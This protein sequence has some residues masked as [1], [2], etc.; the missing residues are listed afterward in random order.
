MSFYIVVK[1]ILLGFALVS[2]LIYQSRRSD[3]HDALQ[4]LRKAPV[5]RPLTEQ[6]V[7]ALEPLKVAEKLLFRPEVRSL[8]GPYRQHGMSIN[9][10]TTMHDTINDVTVLLPY[11]AAAF[12][13]TDNDAEVVISGNIAIVVR[14]NGFDVV[15]GRQRAAAGVTATTPATN[16]APVSKLADSVDEANP[17]TVA[18]APA[19]QEVEWLLERTETPAEAQLRLQQR[20]KKSTALVWLAAVILLWLGA[21]RLGHIAQTMFIIGGLA[22]VVAGIV[23]MLRRPRTDPHPRRRIDRARGPLLMF[24]Q[25]A[26]NNASVVNTHALLGDS[27]KLQLPDHWRNSGRIASGE[28]VEIEVDRGDGRVLGLG[29][30]WSLEDEQKRFP[31]ARWRTPLLLTLV[32]LLGLM[33]ALAGND[34]VVSELKTSIAAIM[35]GTLRQDTSAQSLLKNPP[36]SGDTLQTSGRGFC[37]P[38]LQ[39]GDSGQ[40]IASADCEQMY[41]GSSPL[42]IGSP[43]IDPTMESLY[44]GGYL[45]TQASA[46]R[47][48]L[49]AMLAGSSGYSFGAQPSV[50][51]VS[52]L[53]T[54]VDLVEAACPTA[55]FECDDLKMSLART[56]QL[57]VNDEDG[58]RSLDDWPALAV[59]LRKLADLPRGI[60]F[61]ELTTGDVRGI[62]DLTRGFA[63]ENVAKALAQQSTQ[64]PNLERNGVLLVL[65]RSFLDLSPDGA[66]ASSDYGATDDVG[67]NGLVAQWAR[68][69]QLL[70]S[71]SPFEVNARIIGVTKDN[72]SLRLELSAL[73]DV[74][75]KT[76]SAIGGTLLLLLSLALLGCQLPQLISGIRNAKR[77]REA[78]TEDLRKRPPPGQPLLF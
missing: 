37:A 34:G 44:S 39:H 74:P 50:L 55:S 31:E 65:D 3:N 18:V 1:L 29:N 57:E 10:G 30:G 14:L 7:A 40:S 26:A 64:I 56:L 24:T 63:S 25:R 60:N 73:N 70:G 69:R 27:L 58:A 38:S 49:A 75:G 6:E 11:D 35:P 17:A 20:W 36:S 45:Q 12:L 19:Q 77:R 54:L 59:E 48:M 28:P 43:S 61:I 21:C 78:L 15:S 2:Y 46:S 66:H 22:C 72:G 68:T 33:L 23:L 67:S 8:K 41:W 32:G 71:E 76:P 62:R 52:G 5:A 42:Q 53:H 13:D 16:N 9:S 47:A 51:E 4:V